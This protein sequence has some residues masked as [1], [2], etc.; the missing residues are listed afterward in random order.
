MN[1]FRGTVEVKRSQQSLAVGLSTA[2]VS[3][4]WGKCGPGQGI[5]GPAPRSIAFQ[6]LIV[7]F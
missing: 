5:T 4:G 6:A 3:R 1:C 2:A 7:F